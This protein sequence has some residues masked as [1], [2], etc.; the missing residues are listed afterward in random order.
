MT[1][2]NRAKSDSLRL[3]QMVA[4]LHQSGF[5]RIR[6]G[7]GL[8][9]SGIHWRCSITHSSNV[10][11]NGW[12]PIDEISETVTYSSSDGDG[13]FGWPGASGKSAGQLAEMFNARF[14]VITAQGKGSNRA[15]VLWFSQVLEKAQRGDLP[16]LFADYDLDPAAADLPPPPA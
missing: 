4:E 8:S 12:E 15:Y 9:P 16:V 1:E 14:P 7:P 3:L 11:R 10:R 6:V 13:Y 2:L 5:E